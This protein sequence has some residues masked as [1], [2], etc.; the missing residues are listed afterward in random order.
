LDRSFLPKFVPKFVASGAKNCFHQA[1]AKELM[2]RRAAVCHGRAGAPN[3]LQKAGHHCS[4]AKT[5]CHLK[6]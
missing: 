5:V 6:I 4:G 3:D 1:R 2:T